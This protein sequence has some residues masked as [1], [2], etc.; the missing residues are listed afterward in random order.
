[1]AAERSLCCIPHAWTTGLSVAATHHFAAVTP[2]CPHTEFFHHDFFPSFLRS[3]L[4]DPE[5]EVHDGQW[6]LP[7][8]PGL[9]I[10]LKD[11]IVKQCLVRPLTV[12]GDEYHPQPRVLR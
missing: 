1:M 2:N 7:N 6:I 10:D 4:A 8:K 9:G 5:A 12:S 11:D 3:K